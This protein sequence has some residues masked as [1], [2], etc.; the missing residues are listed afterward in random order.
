MDFLSLISAYIAHGK[1]Q[2]ALVA[3]SG[4]GLVQHFLLILN[5]K[6]TPSKN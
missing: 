5:D 3:G 4:R 2:A 6:E 1:A